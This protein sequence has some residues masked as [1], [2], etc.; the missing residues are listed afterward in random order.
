MFDLAPHPIRSIGR[1]P[2]DRFGRALAGNR[3]LVAIHAFVVPYLQIERSVSERAATLHALATPHTERFINLVLVVR[4]L[5][6]LP[7]DCCRGTKLI[8]R[9]RVLLGRPG[10][11]IAAAQ[12]AVPTNTI[13]MHTLHRRWIEDA[14]GPA[15][16]ALN[17]LCRINLPY[18]VR[19]RRTPQCQTCNP[20]NS[21]PHHTTC[22]RSQ[23]ISSIH[24]LLHILIL[25]G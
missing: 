20:N 21:A 16:S 1:Y 25:T 9:C 24:R 22:C 10:L 17:T 11:M 23:E 3:T 14:V 12:L 8:L 7:L 18:V 2:G 13:G 5:N 19:Y 15:S 6:K 4:L